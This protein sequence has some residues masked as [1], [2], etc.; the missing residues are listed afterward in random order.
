MSTSTR[1]WELRRKKLFE[2]ALGIAI[3]V[4]TLIALLLL[5]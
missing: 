2:Y 3:I 5:S 4:F 1:E